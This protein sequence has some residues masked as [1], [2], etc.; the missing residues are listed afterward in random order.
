V[1]GVEPGPHTVLAFIDWGRSQR[2][3][4]DVDAGDHVALV[5]APG[6]SAWDITAYVKPEG[7]LR[8]TR[9]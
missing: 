2:L 3:R 6:G 5:V 8:L 1:I 7:Y 4:V 9:G